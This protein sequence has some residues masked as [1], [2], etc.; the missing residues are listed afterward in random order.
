MNIFLRDAQ[1]GDIVARMGRV[2]RIRHVTLPCGGQIQMDSEHLDENDQWV[3]NPYRTTWPEDQRMLLL[4][5][6]IS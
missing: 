2:H 4:G 3:L 1:P 5:R 6:G